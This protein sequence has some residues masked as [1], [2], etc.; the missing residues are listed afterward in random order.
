[1]KG[2][3]ILNHAGSQFKIHG[4]PFILC[5]CFVRVLCSKRFMKPQSQAHS[6]YLQVSYP[7]LPS[8]LPLLVTSY[9]CQS[10]AGAFTLGAVTEMCHRDVMLHTL[11]DKA[12]SFFTHVA[13]IS[14]LHSH[15]QPYGFIVSY[16]WA[17]YFSLRI[18]FIWPDTTEINSRL[19]FF[20][21]LSRNSFDRLREKETQFYSFTELPLSVHT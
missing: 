11:G 9:H 10:P 12:K 2:N 6:C 1:M 5:N 19:L 20:F 7:F 3:L 13:S 8:P 16:L 4:V 15:T 21:W 14:L 18:I 17:H